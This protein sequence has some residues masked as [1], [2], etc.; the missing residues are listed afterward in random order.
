[1]QKE[2]EMLKKIESRGVPQYGYV[3]EVQEDVDIYIDDDN[4][5]ALENL[6]L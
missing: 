4:L 3:I 6:L 2:P 1:M 5:H